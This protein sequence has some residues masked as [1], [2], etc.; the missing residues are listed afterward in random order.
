MFAPIVPEADKFK[1]AAVIS[2]VPSEEGRK[3]FGTYTAQVT[4]VNK[5]DGYFR[6]RMTSSV[7]DSPE[8]AVAREGFASLLNVSDEA[9]RATLSV[10]DAVSLLLFL[11]RG[12]DGV[13]RNHVAEAVKLE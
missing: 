7:A 6:Y 1:S 10:G 11:K 13:K 2:V 12:K 3:A 4:C 5:A 8:G 9:A